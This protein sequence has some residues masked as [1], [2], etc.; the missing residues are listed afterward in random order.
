MRHS[1]KVA[2]RILANADQH[3]CISEAELFVGFLDPALAD[4]AHSEFIPSL[5]FGH[6]LIGATELIRS[7]LLPN[8]AVQPIVRR[9]LMELS[10][11]V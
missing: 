4:C 10:A 5:E 3:L 11:A 9:V 1:A 2:E 7:F 8:T 6:W